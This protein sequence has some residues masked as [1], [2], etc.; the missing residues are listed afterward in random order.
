[1]GICA[2]TSLLL[3]GASGLDWAQL[4]ARASA[5]GVPHLAALMREAV[6]APMRPEAPFEGPAP[7]TTLITGASPEAHRVWRYEEAWAG[8]VRPVSRA[9][10]RRAPVWSRL[11]AAGVSTG[12]VAWPA[13]RHGADWPGDHID[14]DFAA[15]T[16]RDAADWTLPIRCARPDLRAA[17]RSLRVHPTQITSDMLRPLAPDLDQID[18]RRDPYLPRL[19]V[20]MARAASVQAAAL[21]LLSERRPDALFVHQPWLAEALG[22]FDEVPAGPF[23]SVIDGAWR[24]LDA[25]IGALVEEAGPA[26]KVALVAPGWRGRAGVAVLR[27]WA[28]PRSATLPAVDLRD[29]A[30]TVLGAFGLDDPDLPG[31]AIGAPGALRPA[32]VVAPPGGPTVDLA[33]LQQ[34][35][36]AGYS[37]PPEV[38]PAWHAHGLSELALAV[39][40][41][42]PACALEVADAAL[43]QNP[44]APGALGAKAL[45]AIA[46]EDPD[47][48][49]ALAAALS[50]AAPDRGW[51]ALAGAAHRVMTQQPAEAAPLLRQAESDPNPELRLRAAALWFAIGRPDQADRIFRDLLRAAPDDPGALV[52]IAMVAIARADYRD[53]EQALVRAVRVDPARGAAWLQLAHVYAKT[54]RRDDADRAAGRAEGVGA[55]P[56]QAQA[57]RTG[58][59]TG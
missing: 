20:G 53:A 8:G 56:Q 10:W 2:V 25:L 38:S 49:P 45:A 31:R 27:G 23:S 48:L 37:A 29:I 21:W 13:A 35:V 4:N 6:A 26:A 39:L 41:R 54:G 43:A 57:A 32:P 22:G 46:L 11:A 9:S 52:G 16:G 3:I 34:A 5:G 19:A 24:F 1:M 36:D 58:R 18:Q 12:S 42:D 17:I 59:L 50:E 28:T 40:G 30:P 15:A 14:R 33:L 7:W 55:T 47:P 51:G 44:S